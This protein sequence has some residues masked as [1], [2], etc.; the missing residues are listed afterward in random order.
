[1]SQKEVQVL[2]GDAL[3]KQ[4]PQSIIGKRIVCREVGMEGPVQAQLDQ[5]FWSKR[6]AYFQDVFEATAEEYQEKTI[7]EL[8]KIKTIRRDA[9]VYLWFEHDLFCQCNLWL[10][11]KLLEQR[12]F[13]GKAYLVLPIKKSEATL[14]QGFG[15]HSPE[16]LQEAWN[17][18][19]LISPREW[20]LMVAC[21][22][23]YAEGRWELLKYHYEQLAPL[24]PY[25]EQVYDA[26]QG[27]LNQ[28]T[29]AQQ[30][31][32]EISERLDTQ[33]FGPIFQE[34]YSTEGVYGYGDLQVH[35]LWQ[36]LNT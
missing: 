14:W 13:T 34:F 28:P 15:N 35:R 33:K 25:W 23:N 4:L 16:E 30:R 22:N 24:L 32:K 9:N 11:A 29:K 17:R 20:R 1:M 8:G 5:E 7:E 18:K 36:E 21:W 3:R 31:L 26:Q 6:S 19:F 27:E 2:N 12:S 10:V